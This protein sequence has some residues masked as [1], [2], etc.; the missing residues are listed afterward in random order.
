MTTAWVREIER[1]VDERVARMMPSDAEMR[2]VAME[3]WTKDVDARMSLRYPSLVIGTPLRTHPGSVHD[4][5]RC[6]HVGSQLNRSGV[7]FFPSY[8]P[9][10]AA[11]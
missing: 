11:A 1:R 2:Q 4:S 3:S 5:P 10:G 6:G 7:F 8:E 9:Q